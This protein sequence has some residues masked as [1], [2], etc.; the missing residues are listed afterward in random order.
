MSSLS[1]QAMPPFWIRRTEV[2]RGFDM[3]AGSQHKP[4][5][6][7]QPVLGP[8]GLNLAENTRSAVEST[9]PVWIQ[10][11]QDS[12]S[13][14]TSSFTPLRKY[15]RLGRHGRPRRQQ[16]RRLRKIS[17][18]ILSLTTS[19]VMNRS[20]TLS[21]AQSEFEQRPFVL[22]QTSLVHVPWK[23][24]RQMARAPN[25]ALNRATLDCQG[26]LTSIVQLFFSH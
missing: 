3:G 17:I 23:S 14:L 15:V 18:V 8:H 19:F 7:N 4:Q 5:R 13:L 12:V 2:A 20:A 26:F 1:T 10:S 6:N 25:T 24:V 16:L 21:P 11:I 9:P 22:T